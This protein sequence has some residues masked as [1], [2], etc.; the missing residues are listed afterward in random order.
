MPELKNTFLEGKMNKDLDARLLK[1]GEYVDA[2]NIYVTKSEGSNVGTAQNIL[3]NKLNYTTGAF[4]SGE[5]TIGVVTTN[6]TDGTNAAGAGYSGTPGVT[7]GFTTSGDGTGGTVNIIIDN[8][9]VTQVTLSGSA[10]GYKV[11][12]TI[13][14][15]KDTGTPAIG[16]S[17][18]VV[19]TLREEDLLITGDI[20][21]VIG[22]FADSERTQD[23]KYR[24]FYFVKGD[25]GSVT[26]NIYYYEAGSTAPVPLIGNTT[27]YLKFNTNYLITG[28]NLIDDLLFWTDNLN[29][30][31]RINVITAKADPT[32]YDSEDKI[33][34]A[35]YYPYLPAKVLR[36][37]DG[38]NHS[39]IQILKT[40]ATLLTAITSATK[41]IVLNTDQDAE[42]NIHVGQE[43]YKTATLSSTNY[44]GLV[45]SISANGLTITS[46][47]DITSI[48]TDT[49]L[50]FLNQD[51][52]L[53]EKFVRFAYRFKF[54][55]G[56]Y[57][58]ISP[59]TQHCFIPRTYNTSYDGHAPASNMIPG[60]TSAQRDSAATTTEVG[61]FINDASHVNLQI[62]LPSATPTSTFE[63]EKIEILVKESDRPSIRSLIQE[64]IT[65]ASVGSDKIYNY[66]YKGALPYK[67]LPESELI[68]VYDNVPT[69][70]RAQEIIGNRLVYGNFQEN[71]N[72]KP[73]STSGGY[74]FDYHVGLAQKD[75]TNADENFHIQYPYHTIKTRRAYQVGIVLADKYGRQSPVFLS[76]DVDKSLIKVKAKD[77]ND[78]DANWKGEALEISFN[79]VIPESDEN[80]VSVLYDAAAPANNPTGWY[81][82]KVVVKQT[83]QDYYN[84]YA[85]GALDNIPYSAVKS[86][87]GA[88]WAD[89][90]KRTWLVLH[91]DNINKVPRD[92]TEESQDTNT[93]P[94]LV[95]LYPKVLSAGTTTDPILSKTPLI[96]II[97]IGKAMDH[98]LELVY[99]TSGVDTKSGHTY[100]PFHNWKK[101]PLL[102]E[103][104]DGYGRSISIT[105]DGT[106]AP[107]HVIGGFTP[108]FS[109]W[110][111]DPFESALDIYYETLTC[112]LISTL[113]TEIGT[114]AGASAAP[115]SIYFDGGD[116][117][118]SF[119]ENISINGIIGGTG[120]LK[121]KDQ[122]DNVI[123]NSGLTYTIVSV[124]DNNDPIPL[125]EVAE[126]H[127]G[128]NDAGSS[129][130]QLKITNLKF[131]YGDSNTG[132]TG[133]EYIVRI[134]VVD[135]S[136]QEY[137]QDFT[138]TLTNSTPIL[139][140][141]VNKDHVHFLSNNT[142]F[143]PYSTSNGSSDPD[144]D[145]LNIAYSITSV[146]YD[147][148]VSTT[149]AAAADAA[150]SQ[151][152]ITIAAA[153]TAIVV[154]MTVYKQG[155]F[156][157]TT[158][159]V[160]ESISGGNIVCV[161]NLAA[162]ITN[163]D[164]L[165][166]S[167]DNVG[168]GTEQQNL[169]K[170]IVN[171][172][173][174]AVSANN[175]VFPSSEAGKIYRITVQS[176]DGSGT[177]NNIHTDSCDVTIGGLSFGALIYSVNFS[178]ICVAL[179]SGSPTQVYYMKRPSTNTSEST[180]ME[181][182]DLIYTDSTLQTA[183]A[184]A[185][186]ITS[187]TGGEEGT[188]FH[189]E[190]T[191][192][193]VDT[194]DVD[195]PPLC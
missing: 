54:K 125:Q 118:A 182:G 172:S 98:G 108:G 143:E 116:N 179:G 49:I 178:G 127:F 154:G 33:S 59:F 159:G 27:N 148:I 106:Q 130:Y 32:Y 174:G 55:D 50:T 86:D 173:T 138:I 45:D 16:G 24:I 153:N 144:Q 36:Q 152:N 43:I 79:K 78:L 11:G 66:T 170:F 65:D 7:S 115:S 83:E 26:D 151:K 40:Q 113:N 56:E 112:G 183:V 122:S 71:P 19:L 175:H 166:F 8:N 135:G 117:T 132:G 185:Y 13:T 155:A 12:D 44:L 35:K 158:V 119:P 111:T 63:I 187:I 126:T 177:S 39:G 128:I 137:S 142:I 107:L 114:G 10:S 23:D 101:N 104:Q 29:Q 161:A 48:A 72:N 146:L 80:G 37:V 147:P 109:V 17:T 61:S 46:D 2:Q 163:G 90:D 171:S 41:T 149:G 6:T 165:R 141:P 145:E 14:I 3:G 129:V 22:Y 103:I 181:V 121:T 74:S 180:A 150:T 68:R 25:S 9:T 81:S 85:P 192:G 62:E 160:I 176:N 184:H 31:R 156:A 89:V 140:M 97:S 58:L 38:T 69:K 93:A 193:V 51:D 57:S 96:D 189:N 47:T 73:Y 110:E 99:E 191:S 120:G 168:G 195:N 136:N 100:L 164:A 188:G 95:S 92:T 20:G 133:H 82:Y 105:A 190:V 139:V 64:K 53:K 4:K 34:V 28:V 88:Y 21:T 5:R 60:L 94:A 169:A 1:N 194:V 87:I 167:K 102:A 123:A 186:I 42:H 124:H 162:A 75:S 76:D 91:G 77:S 15:S 131:Y 157:N 52:E 67:T 30:P 18:N 84:V 70:A 134:K